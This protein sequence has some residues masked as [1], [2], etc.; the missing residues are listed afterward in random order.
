V[1]RRPDAGRLAL[2]VPPSNIWASNPNGINQ[3]GC[4]YTA[5]GL[6]FDSVGVIV[7][8]DL[9]WDPATSDWIGDPSESHESIVKRGPR[10]RFT[11]LVKR[12]YRVLLTRGMKGCYVFAMDGAISERLRARAE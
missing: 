9:R 1:E 10:D 2:N 8:R 12:T 7:G 5:Q 3:V 11:D 4:V 6:E